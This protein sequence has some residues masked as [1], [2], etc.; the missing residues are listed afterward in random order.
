MDVR[1]GELH[2]STRLFVMQARRKEVK[3][4]LNLRWIREQ[5]GSSAGQDNL[6]VPIS[7]DF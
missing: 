5:A 4:N 6:I 1:V 7:V 3:T 2:S